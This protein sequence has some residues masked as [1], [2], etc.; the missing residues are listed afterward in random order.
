MNGTLDTKIYRPFVREMCHREI[1]EKSFKAWKIFNATCV[2]RNICLFC[3]ACGTVD[4]QGHSTNKI[5]IFFLNNNFCDCSYCQ[6]KFISN[7]CSEMY[8]Y[9]KQSEDK[10]T[11]AYL[12]SSLLKFSICRAVYN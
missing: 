6:K 1:H 12:S 5:I 10:D 11:C 9:K 4:N 2:L 7:K 8:L 3:S